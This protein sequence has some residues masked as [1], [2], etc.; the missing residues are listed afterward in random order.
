MTTTTQRDQSCIWHPYTQHQTAD[1]PKT[2]VRGEGAYLFDQDSRRYLDLISSWWVNI[3]GHSHPKIAKAIYDQ[4]LT[5][6]H[7]IFSGFTHEPAVKLAEKLLAILPDHFSKVF[8]SDNGSTA[9]EVALKMAYQYWRNQG[10]PAKKRFIGF[11]K[12]YHGDTFGSMATG[13][14]SK[15]FEHFG[16]L[17]FS[18]DFFPYP[19]TWQHD[20]QVSEKEQAVLTALKNHLEQ[21]HQEIA[22]MIIEPLV[23]GAS[24]MRMCRPVFL[25]ELDKLMKSYQV[26]VIYDEVMTGFGRTGD[27][28]ACTKAN[29]RPDIICVA[30]GLTGGFLPLSATICHES[31]YEAFL[32]D[33]FQQALAHGHSFAGNPLGCAAALA[34]LALL[35][36]PNTQTKMQMIETIH[37]EELQRLAGFE[38]IE[39]LRYCG[40]IAAFDVTLPSEYGSET[41]LALRK[42]FME[43]GLVIRPIANV[44]YL[45]PPYC[46][47]ADDLREAYQIILEE[48]Q[49]VFS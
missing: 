18:V 45:L 4:A 43:R 5:L 48:I 23:Q 35:T 32:G 28:F 2:I 38:H 16:D 49:G 1:L 7:V 20:S 40:T 39:K 3:H 9:I 13:K 17:F 47:S 42:R 12:G 15:F 14:T 30:K 22:A 33:H 11:E 31:I 26:L 27:Y 41:S 19:E 25:Q 34:S 36:H 24:G 46:I 29:T 44:V 8:Y 21:Y 10:Q 6:E 37:S